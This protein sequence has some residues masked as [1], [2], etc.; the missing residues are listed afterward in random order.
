CGAGDGATHD[1]PGE[2]GRRG[3]RIAR[4][5]D[6]A[7]HTLYR[8]RLAPRAGRRVVR[9]R[10][11]PAGSTPFVFAAVGDTGDGSRS[12][13]QLARRI[14]ARRPGFVVPLGDFAYP[15]GTAAEY[16]REF[17][18]PYARLLARVPLMPTPGN[19]DLGRRS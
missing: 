18:R 3:V 7:P 12:A 15:R 13:A 10:T 14:L 8:C 4:L 17:F 2:R 11:A 6:L 19:H 9:F 16:D 5:G 1:M